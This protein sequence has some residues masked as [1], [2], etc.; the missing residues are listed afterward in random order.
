MTDRFIAEGKEREPVS[1]LFERWRYWREGEERNVGGRG[2]VR[3]F[4]SR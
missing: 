1:E 3:R 2:P 4:E